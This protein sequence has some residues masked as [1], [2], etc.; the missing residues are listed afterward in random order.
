VKVL[1]AIRKRRSIRRFKE[2]P[3]PDQQIERLLEAAQ[4]APSGFNVQPWQFIFVEDK[5]LKR[6]LRG[7]MFTSAKK[8]GRL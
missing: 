8:C 4:L 2:T 5:E 7:A 3:V 1:E 6:G